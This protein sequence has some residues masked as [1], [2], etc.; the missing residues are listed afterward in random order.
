MKIKICGL[1]PAR[2]VQICIDLK[3]NQ[4]YNYIMKYNEE[5]ILNEIIEYIK[6]TYGQHYSTGKDGFQV[7][8]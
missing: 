2:D 6:S 5:K 8:D 1:N 3:V 7:Q 4:C